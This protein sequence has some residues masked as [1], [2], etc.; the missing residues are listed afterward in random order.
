MS[1][2]TKKWYKSWTVWYNIA[3]IVVDVVNQIA[4]FIPLPAGVLTLVGSI[5]NILLRFKTIQPIG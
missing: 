5:G 2:T 3:L 1:N 4:Q